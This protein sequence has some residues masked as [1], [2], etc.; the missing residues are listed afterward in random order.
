MP[1]NYFYGYVIYSDKL[2]E[3]GRGQL[4][5]F[6]FLN[7]GDKNPNPKQT[8]KLT[9]T[10]RKKKQV[11]HIKVNYNARGFTNLKTEVNV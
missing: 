8:S 2:K 10:T 5:G 7:L 4:A 11:W 6:L 3:R 1:V 9:T